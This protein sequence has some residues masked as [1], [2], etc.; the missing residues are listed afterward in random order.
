MTASRRSP[1]RAYEQ[2]MLKY[3]KRMVRLAAV[4]E[5]ELCDPAV[6]TELGLPA[7][8]PAE[9]RAI[10]AQTHAASRL[11]PRLPKRTDY[12][13]DRKESPWEP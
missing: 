6:L 11:G 7:E 2:A 8:L 5:R 13:P 10:L 3:Q 4:R 1:A 12:E 9:T